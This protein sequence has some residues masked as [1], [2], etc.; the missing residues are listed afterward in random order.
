[1]YVVTVV[2]EVA[3][4]HVEAFAA[5]MLAQA[6][7]SLQHEDGCLRF[8]VCRDPDSPE[9]TFL[10]EIYRDQ[11]AF[12]LHLESAHFKAFD[13]QVADWVVCK[14]VQTYRLEN[15]DA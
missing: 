4:A 6:R 11:P 2:F 5:A 10:Y 9:T 7:N 14:T 12:R 8:D 13:R 15:P 1:M 3:S